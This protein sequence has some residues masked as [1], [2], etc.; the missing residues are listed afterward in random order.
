ME[1][2]RTDSDM[3]RYLR[4]RRSDFQRG[5][6]IRPDGRAA[7]VT[8]SPEA[9]EQALPALARQGAADSDEAVERRRTC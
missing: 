1:Q 2:N 9:Y 5:S 3:L 7:T 8:L 6:F 4:Q